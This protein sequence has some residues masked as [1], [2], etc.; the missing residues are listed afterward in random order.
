MP[1]KKLVYNKSRKNKKRKSRRYKLNN[2][3]RK[4]YRGGD[5]EYYILTTLNNNNQFDTYLISKENATKN[6]IVDSKIG[7][8]DANNIEYYKAVSK[9][10][11]NKFTNIIEIGY[12]INKND[13]KTSPFNII[14]GNKIFLTSHDIKKRIKQ[15]I[16]FIVWLWTTSYN[17]T[18]IRLHR[19]YMI[20]TDINHI[21]KLNYFTDIIDIAENEINNCYKNVTE[22]KNIFIDK[23][24]EKKIKITNEPIVVNSNDKNGNT[25]TN[26]NDNNYTDERFH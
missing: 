5:D 23:E 13:M 6:L 8:I 20:N 9:R 10:I 26:N 18:D 4:M 14:E 11:V 12:G 25:N 3:S 17:L 24:K 19:Y 16:Y 2:K 1:I 21:E 15:N 22:Y 7:S